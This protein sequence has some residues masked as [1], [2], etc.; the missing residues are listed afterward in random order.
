[1][2]TNFIFISLFGFVVLFITLYVI[3]AIEVDKEMKEARKQR[4][5]ENLNITNDENI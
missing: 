1:M 4:K 5:K 2:W 3:S